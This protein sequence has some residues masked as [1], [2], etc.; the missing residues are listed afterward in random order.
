MDNQV[1]STSQDPPPA[2]T[3]THFRANSSEKFDQLIDILFHAH[4]CDTS[5]C[6]LWC[7]GA[8]WVLDHCWDCQDHRKKGCHYCNVMVQ[9]TAFHS[10]NCVKSPCP[11]H[12]CET[13]KEAIKAYPPGSYHLID[14][15]HLIH[16]VHYRLQDLN[17]NRQLEEEEDGEAE[18]AVKPKWNPAFV[19][20]VEEISS[21]TDD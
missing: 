5:G 18:A 4:D 20:Q 11:L 14:L 2:L 19:E 9:V 16:R 3:S 13:I 7:W 1:S 21:T 10:R 12:F 17:P 8:K 6:N 15:D